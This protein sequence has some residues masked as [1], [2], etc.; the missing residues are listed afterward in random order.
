MSKCKGTVRNDTI[1]KY[2]GT[3]RNSR[4]QMFFKTSALKSF[5]NFTVKQLCWS[6]FLIKL[7]A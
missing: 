4:P 1:S 2:R 5:A 3:V 7:K 6:L